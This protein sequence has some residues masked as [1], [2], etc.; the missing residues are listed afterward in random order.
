VRRAAGPGQ[1]STFA[2]FFGFS[3]FRL[4][5]PEGTHRPESLAFCDGAASEKGARSRASSTRYGWVHRGALTQIAKTTPC[6]V[7]WSPVPRDLIIGPTPPSA[8][9]NDLKPF[10]LS[11]VLMAVHKDCYTSLNLTQQGGLRRRETAIR[12]IP[13]LKRGTAPSSCGVAGGDALNAIGH[14]I[15]VYQPTAHT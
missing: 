12:I 1:R 7:E 4:F 9:L 14:F 8:G 2:R 6:K 3:I 11:T 13:R 5:Q 10:N 15:V